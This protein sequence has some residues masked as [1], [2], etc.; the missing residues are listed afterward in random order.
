MET[1][2]RKFETFL[3]NSMTNPRHEGPRE[4]FSVFDFSDNNQ[5]PKNQRKSRQRVTSR[6]TNHRT[7]RTNVDNE[8]PRRVDDELW[9]KE[10]KESLKR[11]DLVGLNFASFSGSSSFT[12]VH[13]PLT[14]RHSVPLIGSQTRG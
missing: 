7:V 14:A 13:K 10:K 5:V 2:G 3:R 6:R 11:K 8:N 1:E 4:K 9:K 12:V